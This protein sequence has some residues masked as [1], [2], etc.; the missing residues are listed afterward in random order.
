MLGGLMLLLGFMLLYQRRLAAV[1]RLY[2]LQSLGL[3]AAAAWQAH[4]QAQPG[5][6]ITAL[7]ALG[8]K[9]IAIPLA[10]AAVVRRTNLSRTI[11]PALGI[12]P[13]L[14]LGVGLVS[15]AIV[16]VLPVTVAVPGGP[17]AREDLALALSVVLLGLLVMVTRRNAIIQVIGFMTME[18]GLILAA[19]GA[20]GM[21][22]AVELAIAAL[23]LVAFLVFGVVFFRIRERFVSL[24]TAPLDRSPAER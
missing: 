5:L 9:G 16:V 11:D 2:A 21:P 18:N 14:I 1:I 15:L 10:L 7:L 12:A 13:T 4:V 8:A 17:L 24:D 20:A 6:Y 3:A 23:V 22:L 19:V